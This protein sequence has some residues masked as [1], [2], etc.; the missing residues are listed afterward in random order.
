MIMDDNQSHTVIRPKIHIKV[1]TRS[2]VIPVDKPEDRP[3]RARVHVI[4][5]EQLLLQLDMSEY[6][7]QLSR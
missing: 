2:N 4:Y 7:V 6:I 1:R 3:I 5:A